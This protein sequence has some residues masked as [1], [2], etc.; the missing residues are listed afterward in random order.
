MHIVAPQAESL[1][2]EGVIA[3]EM[4]AT[5]EDIGLSVHPHP[6]L[7]EVDHGRRRSRPRQSHSHRQPQAEEGAGRGTALDERCTARARGCSTW[8]APVSR[9]LGAAAPAARRGA[10]R[11]RARYVDRRRAHA[12]RH[13]GTPGEARERL[14]LG[15]ASSRARGIDVVAIERGGDV[16]YHGPGQLVVYPIRRLARF[17]EV[18]P[19]VRA[20]EGAVIAACARF[21]VAA[22]RWSE[23]RRRLGRAQPDLCDRPC[24]AARWSRCTASRSTSRPISTTTGSS[25]RADCPTAASRRSRR[26][27]GRDVGIDEAKDVLLAELARTFDVDFEP[28]EASAWRMAIEIDLT[29]SHPKLAPT[30]MHAAQA[31]LAAR[32]AA[33]GR[34]LRTRQGQGQRARTPHRVQGSR[35]PEPRPSAGAPAPRRS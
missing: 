1:I 24:R 32:F 2:G 33:V 26:K 6:T 23:T 29:R 14:A 12:G 9:G 31:R 20:L 34:R 25:R 3:L 18:V 27:P 8:D 19:L 7:T 4:G 21:G 5:L 10:R 13:A 15:R 30:A 22:E 11:P 28:A 17:R 35:V 16:T